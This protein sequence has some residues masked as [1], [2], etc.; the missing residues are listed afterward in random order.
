MSDNEAGGVVMAVFGCGSGFR[1]GCR[2]ACA[3]LVDR[4]RGGIFEQIF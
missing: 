4:G 2:V 1:V 3:S